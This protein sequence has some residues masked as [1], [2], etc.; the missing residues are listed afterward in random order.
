[1]MLLV[2]L[3]ASLLIPREA[4]QYQAELTREVR[5]AWGM[6]GPVAAMGAQIDQESHWREKVCSA[7][8]C[9]LSQFTPATAGWVSGL[10]AQLGKG[11]PLDPHWAIR[12]MVLYDQRLYDGIKTFNSACDRY[13]LSLS[14]YNGGDGWRISR[15]AHSMAPGDYFITSIINPGIT[16]AN[17]KQNQEYPIRIVYMLQPVYAAWG[18]KRVC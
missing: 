6:D 8:A 1:M 14:S 11:S 12:A 7:Y 17:Q 3:A 18:T 2:V 9:G 10:Y 16:A 4:F 13:L 5:Y 15:Q